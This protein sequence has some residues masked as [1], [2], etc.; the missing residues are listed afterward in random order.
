ML[1]CGFVV[2]YVENLV[3]FVG[4]VDFDFDFVV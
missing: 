4:C 1:C 2:E 3:D